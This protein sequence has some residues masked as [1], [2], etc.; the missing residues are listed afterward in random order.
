MFQ[1]AICSDVP[2]LYT[3]RYLC[4]EMTLNELFPTEAWHSTAESLL[5]TTGKNLPSDRPKR[6]HPKV[7]ILNYFYSLT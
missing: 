4:E 7:Y 2:I 5:V 1:I 6:N 3:V